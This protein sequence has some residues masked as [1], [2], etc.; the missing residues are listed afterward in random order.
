M[1]ASS[2]FERK[3]QC[4]SKQICST[5]SGRLRFRASGPARVSKDEETLTSYGYRIV[6]LAEFEADTDAPRGNTRKVVRQRQAL[7]REHCGVRPR[8][9]RPSWL[10]PG[11][12]PGR[13]RTRDGRISV[14]WR[15]L[16]TRHR[17]TDLNCRGSLV[18]AFK[19]TR[20]RVIHSR[21]TRSPQ[22]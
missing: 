8:G 13:S 11:R 2:V 17:V 12:R 20:E 18:F 16:S 4:L 6:T 22:D 5:W 1:P 3:I 15:T 14:R 19:A 21:G 7:R 10:A 9:R